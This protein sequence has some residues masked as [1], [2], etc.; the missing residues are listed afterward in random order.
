MPQSIHASAVFADKQYHVPEESYCAIYQARHILGLLYDLSSGRE[1]FCDLHRE[2]LAVGLGVVND[3]I[4]GVFPDLV[5]KPK[6]AQ[7]C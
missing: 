7:L 4:D 1:E 6:G 2:H 5:F 3:L